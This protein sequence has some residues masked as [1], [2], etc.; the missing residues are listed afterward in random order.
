MVTAY[1]L[2]SPDLLGDWLG[3]RPVACWALDTALTCR[4]VDRVVLAA[5]APPSW[6][7]PE[8]AAFVA[9][10]AAGGPPSLEAAAAADDGPAPEVLLAVH[11]GTVFLSPGTV[12]RVLEAVSSGRKPAA[13]TAR[14]VRNAVPVAGPARPLD[15]AVE[16]PGCL[17]VRRDALGRPA[18][19]ELV[20]ADPMELVDV[21]DPFEG[22]A[23]R[24]LVEQGVA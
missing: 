4:G 20:D 12:E 23:V 8:G 5:P 17:A 13:C 2:A 22:A 14:V 24:A 11:P 19:R 16:S 10:P 1:V 9:V 15:V 7:L 18:A 3:S 21:T 6:A